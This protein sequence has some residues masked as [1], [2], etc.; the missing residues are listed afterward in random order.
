M[1]KVSASL[2]LHT[3]NPGEESRMMAPICSKSALASL[4]PTM[5]GTSLRRMVVSALK[6]VMVRLGTL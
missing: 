4:T 3:R 1:W 5:L 6:L 2:P